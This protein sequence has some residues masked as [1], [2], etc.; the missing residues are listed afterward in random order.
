M[1]KFSD[2]ALTLIGQK[3]LSSMEASSNQDS[4]ASTHDST[5]TAQESAPKKALVLLFRSS[6]DND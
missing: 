3:L 5:L 4:S 6:I 2:K 1:I